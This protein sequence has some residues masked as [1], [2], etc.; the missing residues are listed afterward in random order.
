MKILKNSCC[1]RLTGVLLFFIFAVINFGTAGENIGYEREALLILPSDA[2]QDSLY[3]GI[4]RE[5][6][7]LWEGMIN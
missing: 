2:E 4:R 7:T 3:D 5:Y 1:A 6:Q